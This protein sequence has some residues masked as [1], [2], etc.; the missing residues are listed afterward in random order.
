VKV[1]LG[2]E[3]RNELGSWCGHPSYQSGDVCGVLEA[4]LRKVKSDGW[5]IVGGIAWKDIRKLRANSP[6]EAERHNVRALVL[7]AREAGCDLVAFV[8]DRDGAP[9]R[10]SAVMDGLR[11]VQTGADDPI[12]IGGMAIEKIEGWMLALKG[13]HRS[14]THKHPEKQTKDLGIDDKDT[15]EM[16]QTIETADF[17]RLPSDATSLQ[18][19]LEQARKAFGLA[20]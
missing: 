14:E 16:V 10:E 5:S 19:W 18:G 3:G 13:Q 8:R 4:L 9:D 1:F 11:E 15:A 6:G 20:E 12:V 2:G 7:K 17:D